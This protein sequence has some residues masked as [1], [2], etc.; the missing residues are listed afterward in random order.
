MRMRSTLPVLGALVAFAVAGAQDRR[1]NQDATGLPQGETMIAVDPNNPQHLVATWME[2][3]APRGQLVTTAHA[4]SLD[5]GATWQTAITNAPGVLPFTGRIDPSVAIDGLGNVY[6]FFATPQT[7]ATGAAVARSSDGGLTFT[8]AA[9]LELGESVD[10]P[11]IAADPLS[12]NVYVTYT[13]IVSGANAIKFARSLDHGVTFSTPAAISGVG[14]GVNPMLAVGP[15]GEVYIVYSGGTIVKLDRSLDNGAT[16]LPLDRTVAATTPPPFSNNGGLTALLIPTI[17]VDRTN[18]PFRGRLYVAWCDG[19]NADTDIYMASSADQGTTWTAPLRVN[20]DYVGGGTDQVHPTLWVDDAGH[21]HVQFLD[22]RED[23]ANLKLAVYLATSTNGGVSFGPNV[24]ISD[25]GFVQG[26]LPGRPNGWLGDYGG[27]AGAG[28]TNHIVWADGRYGDLDIFY[29]AVNDADFDVDGILN[30][31]SGDGQYANAPCTGGLTVGCD[32]N[33]PGVSNSTQTD[34]DGDGVGDAC[35]N[36]PSIPNADRFDRDRD[37][38]GDACDPC[39]ANANKPAGDPDGDGVAECADNCPGLPNASQ[40]DADAD[41]MGDF[42]DVCPGSATND[43]DHDGRCEGADNCA[44][45]W[46]PKQVDADGDS[47][48]DACDNCPGDVNAAQTD[49]DGDGQ[50]D[51]CDCQPAD[52]S[53][54][55]PVRIEELRAFKSGTTASFG[56]IGA[57]LLG[58]G[59]ALHRAVDAYSVARGLLSTLR[60]TGT[61]GPCFLEGLKRGVDDASIPPPGDGF[62]YLTQAQNYECGLGSLG[63][64]SNEVLR[65]NSDALACKGQTYV[66]ASAS[67]E[68]HVRGTVTGTL[69]DVTS[70]DNAYE[71]ITEVLI[72]NVSQLDH[73][74]TFNVP[75][76]AVLLEV[77]IEAFYTP[78]SPTSAAE[79]VQIDYSVDGGATWEWLTVFVSGPLVD[80]NAD[81]TI[82]IPVVAG[83][84]SVRVIDTNRTT[85]SPGLDGISIDQLWIRTAP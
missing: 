58:P 84:M 67:S 25:P 45:V 51:A 77:H 31:G 73:R 35:D 33:C 49:T 26:G 64:N 20:D 55:A 44:T 81:R 71:S 9:P 14:G 59:S 30:D 74:W 54:G 56:W 63:V 2:W 76:G 80:N 83:T 66:D 28:G 75:V 62:V 34:S 65:S 38:V 42:C 1:L 18:G 8:G 39:P 6:E 15:V 69:A 78:S 41:G 52:G 50:G 13:R 32:D 70:S 4:R 68:T 19:R 5:G 12:N 60:S 23:P 48:G 82:G 36:C 37:G 43:Q 46:N 16:W 7:L 21:V 85:S 53:D 72:S 57:G 47:I 10:K 61:F 29:R 3:D 79:P 11:W 24:R 17:A 22:R 27:G 40:A